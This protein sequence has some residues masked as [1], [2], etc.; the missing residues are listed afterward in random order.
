MGLYDTF[1]TDPE[2]EKKGVILDYGDFRVRIGY[3]GST[4]KRYTAYAEKKF[5]PL[6]HAINNGLLSEERSTAIMADIYAETLIYEWETKVSEGENGEPEYKPGIE[7]K[8]KGDLLPFN[9]E[10]VRKTLQALPNLLADMKMQ[11]ESISNFA[12]KDRE[13]DSGNSS[14]S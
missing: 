12:N 5:K 14:G 9:K 11:A 4:N 2:I 8:E 10:N 6:R 3:A 13:G 1:Q 7:P